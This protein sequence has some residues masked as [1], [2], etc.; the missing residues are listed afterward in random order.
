MDELKEVRFV[1]N[2]R[3]SIDTILIHVEGEIWRVYFEDLYFLT[4]EGRQ[5]VFHE[6][7]LQEYNLF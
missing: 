1:N 5:G 6:P 4:P 3:T 2:P 7:L